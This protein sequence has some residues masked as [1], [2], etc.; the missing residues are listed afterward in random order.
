MS[1]FDQ[2]NDNLDAG[3]AE[4]VHGAPGRIANAADARRFMTAGKATVTFVS[5]RTQARFTYR[6]RLSDD[7]RLYFV[8]VLTGN[9]NESSFS[10]LGHMFVDSMVYW[11][12]KKSKISR[13]APSAKAFAWVWQQLIRGQLPDALEIWHEGRCGR[14][15][16]KLTVPESIASGFGPECAGKIGAA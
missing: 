15:G 9:D 11:H 4:H 14:C 1:L 10:Y 8:N 5:T 3:N 7:K 13:E 16:R 12:G 6:L 2:F